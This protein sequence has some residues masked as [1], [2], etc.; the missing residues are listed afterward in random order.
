MKKVE[1]SAPLA[2]AKESTAK[3]E[4]PKVEYILLDFQTATQKTLIAD[5]IDVSAKIQAVSKNLYTV[6]V[7]HLQ[8]RKVFKALLF[9][10]LRLLIGIMRVGFSSLAE[11]YA[12]Y[13]I[14]ELASEC[15]TNPDI[16]QRIVGVCNI[17]IRQ[18]SSVSGMASILLAAIERNAATT[19]TAQPLEPGFRP[20]NRAEF[21]AILEAPATLAATV[22]DAL[23]DMHES[24]PDVPVSPTV[25]TSVQPSADLSRILQRLSRL[26]KNMEA[27][28]SECGI[29]RRDVIRVTERLDAKDVEC[30]GLREEIA[31][32]TSEMK[33]KSDECVR[34]RQQITDLEGAG[35][36]HVGEVA[37]SQLEI[38]ESF[39]DL[40]G[41]VEKLE[42]NGSPCLS[43][44]EDNMIA[45]VERKMDLMSPVVY[46]LIGRVEKLE[47]HGSPCLSAYEDK[48]IA[49]VERKMDLMTPVVYERLEMTKNA[50]ATLANQVPSDL[51]HQLE[52]VRDQLDYLI[53]EKVP[54]GRVFHE[55]YTAGHCDVALRLLTDVETFITYTT[56]VEASPFLIRKLCGLIRVK[57]PRFNKDHFDKLRTDQGT[58]SLHAFEANNDPTKMRQDFHGTCMDPGSASTAMVFLEKAMPR[59]L[60]HDKLY[61]N[62]KIV[63]TRLA[64]PAPSS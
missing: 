8:Y 12:A 27:K 61:P 25:D 57:P 43:A 35:T 36:A 41:R 29:L 2:A 39:D 55:L 1:I 5:D 51:T 54:Y 17:I 15:K 3:D 16:C 52:T 42:S 63:L 64:T 6:L 50:C 9:N 7:D 45:A 21:E 20:M 58:A 13:V 56:S 60:A 14:R 48:V 24:P 47:S 59:F 53:D 49:A 28:D 44:Y 4:E 32:L 30:K 19:E 62:H 37:A 46:D 40:I 38:Q 31:R 26:E 22:H 10:I 23:E 34:M 11:D 33:V 18:D